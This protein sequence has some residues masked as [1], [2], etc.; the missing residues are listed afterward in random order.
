MVVRARRRE[1]AAASTA[2]AGGGVEGGRGGKGGRGQEEA[3]ERERLWRVVSTCSLTWGVWVWW[4][5]VRRS[6]RWILSR[7]EGSK[8]RVYG[9]ELWVSGSEGTSGFRFLDSVT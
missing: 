6:E 4:L 5:R 7:V 3:M 2:D 8:A 1:C 9:L